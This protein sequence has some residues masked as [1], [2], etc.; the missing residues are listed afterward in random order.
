MSSSDLPEANFDDVFTEIEDSYSTE[1][2]S[3]REI[4]KSITDEKIELLYEIGRTVSRGYIF[5]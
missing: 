3:S 5:V 4:L 2:E 1:D